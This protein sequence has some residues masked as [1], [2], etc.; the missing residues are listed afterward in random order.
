MAADSTPS[1]GDRGAAAVA[2]DDDYD[3]DDD[4]GG[5]G[6]GCADTLRYFLHDTCLP[7]QRYRRENNW[8]RESE[9][10]TASYGAV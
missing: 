8:S 1:S 4:D 6:G 10:M 2:D 7:E 3:D 9:R 5:G